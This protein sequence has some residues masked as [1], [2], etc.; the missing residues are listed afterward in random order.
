MGEMHDKSDLDL[1]YDYA[2]NA[3]EAAFREIVVRYADL[4]YSSALRQVESSHTAADIA[5]NVFLDLAHKAGHLSGEHPGSTSIV[6]WLHRAT[7]YTVLNHLR[8]SHRRITNERQAMEQLLTNSD[9]SLDWEQIRPTLDEALDNL[10]DE[11]RE[12]LLLRYFKNQTLRAV[13]QQVGISEDAAQK[14]VSRALEKLRDFFSKHGTAVGTGG[15]ALIVSANAVQAAPAGLAISLSTTALTGGAVSTTFAAAST[16]TIAMTTLQKVLVTATVA[17]LTGAGIYEAHQAA[18]L[19]RLA[20]TLQQQ[21]APLIEQNRQLRQAR[22]EAINQLVD[23]PDELAKARKDNL[24]LLRLRNEVSS[25]REQ[26]NLLANLRTSTPP[27]TAASDPTDSKSSSDLILRENYTFAGYA[28]PEATVKSLFWA[29]TQADMQTV[30]ASMSPLM[31]AQTEAEWAGKSEDQIR[32]ELT[33]NSVT[34]YRITDTLVVS[35]N[36]KVLTVYLE[37]RNVENKMRIVR[38]ND[39]WK[40]AGKPG[41]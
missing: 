4:V 9:A 33:N 15:L 39:E 19:R 6:G 11:D 20:L 14:R 21:Q 30:L 16:K 10:S 1:L 23:L 41:R 5:Q 7:R 32:A 26:T 40:L 27:K 8:N 37:G 28:A 36:E 31:K 29:A 17:I 3:S 25:L 35:D 13:G 12:V 2:A 18:Q 38:V 22:S 34:G 24:E